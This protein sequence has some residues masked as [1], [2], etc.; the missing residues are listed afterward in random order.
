MEYAAWLVDLDGT[1]YRPL[2]VKLAMGAELLL[3]GRAHLPAIRAFRRQHEVLRETLEDAVASPFELQLERAASD[4][5]LAVDNLRAI[6]MEWMVERPLRWLPRFARRGL[7]AEIAGFRDAGGKTALVSDYPAR[8]KLGALGA[9]E[10]FDTVV[11][12]GEENGPGR[13]KPWPDGYLAAAE[14]L[15]VAPRECLVIG[16]RA[17]ADGEAAR[18]A[19]MAFRRV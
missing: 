7:L 11:A 10:L 15:G 6:V 17:D 5:S 1:L 18:R 2:P 16:D 12:N 9:A 4:A 8:A 14:R 3:A 13:L 19:R